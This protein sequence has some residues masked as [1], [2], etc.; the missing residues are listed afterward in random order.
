[1]G[2]ISWHLNKLGYGATFI[3]GG[4]EY[5]MDFVSPFQNG[6]IDQCDRN[7]LIET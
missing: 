6:E 7:V 4:F 5:P 2:E 1:M 3:D